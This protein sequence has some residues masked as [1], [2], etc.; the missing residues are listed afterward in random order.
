MAMEQNSAIGGLGNT[1]RGIAIASPFAMSRDG[2]TRDPAR[3]SPLYVLKFVQNFVCHTC[4][5][6]N[7]W[8]Q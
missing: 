1:E 7:K 5:L 8:L 2:T 4:Y 3:A 6:K